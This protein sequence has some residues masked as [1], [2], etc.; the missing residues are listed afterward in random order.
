MLWTESCQESDTARALVKGRPGRTG[1]QTVSKAGRP[2]HLSYR[3]SHGARLASVVDLNKEQKGNAP[4]NPWYLL[5]RGI[6]R[7]STIS[8]P[9]R[10]RPLRPSLRLGPLSSAFYAGK[11]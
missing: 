3:F 5:Q 7:D 1:S 6:Q 8:L 4:L 11:Q 9:L 10:A 2:Q